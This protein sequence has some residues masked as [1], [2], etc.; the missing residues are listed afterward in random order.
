VAISPERLTGILDVAQGPDYTS[1]LG[2]ALRPEARGGRAFALIRS[3]EVL[4]SALAGLA[5]RGLAIPTMGSSAGQRVAGLLATSSH[6]GDFDLPPPADFV[7]AVH[8]VRADGSSL[9][10]EGARDRAITTAAGAARAAGLD[11]RSVVYDDAL[12]DAARVS[13]GSL[14]VIYALVLEVE[15]M[16]HLRE[17]FARVPWASL[18]EGLRSGQIFVTPPVGTADVVAGEPSTYSYLELLVNPYP[19]DG[20]V[21]AGVVTRFRSRTATAA[22]WQRPEPPMSLADQLRVL[23]T[24]IGRDDDAFADVI[25]QLQAGNRTSSGVYAPAPD[26]C[27]T[28]GDHRVPVQSLEL[29]ISTRGGRHVALLDRLL[30]IFEAGRR[31]GRDF[32]GFWTVRATRMSSAPLAMQARE[33]VDGAGDRIVHVEIAGLQKIDVARPG[34]AN[35]AELEVDNAAFFDAFLDAGRALGARPHWG[36]WTNSRLPHSIFGYERGDAWLDAKRRLAVAGALTAFDNDFSA[37]AG[38]IPLAPGWSVTGAVP[39]SPSRA[40]DDTRLVRSSAPA[41]CV[42]GGVA[43]V[44]AASGDGRLGTSLVGGSWSAAAG[45]GVIAGRVAL[46]ADGAGGML[47]TATLDDGRL[48]FARLRGGAPARLEPLDGGQR[49]T[50]APVPVLDG[51]GTVRVYALERGGALHVRRFLRD[52]DWDGGWS[53]LR[54]SSPV[55]APLPACAALGPTGEIELFAR[56]GGEVLLLRDRAGDLEVAR[57]G[58][59]GAGEAACAATA[60]ATLVA[61]AVSGRVSAMVRRAG[62][63]WFVA[64]TPPLPPVLA[65]TGPAAL[66]VG[67]HIVVG[68]VDTA[69][70][71]VLATRAPDGSWTVRP[72]IE[73]GACGGPAL[74]LLGGSIVLATRLAHDIVQTSA[75]LLGR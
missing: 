68:T 43:A 13:A 6:G 74:A 12:L 58:L 64:E 31:A 16:F 21:E 72:P 50:G 40:P 7:R 54:T 75:I 20:V 46:V 45:D 66:A 53:R 1:P 67:D 56:A 2:Q 14:G 15:P 35:P 62:E 3:G 65:G 36:Q 44:A 51:G 29:A 5:A 27:D 25:D 32:A 60:S 71:V 10:I 24:V 23:T 22:S 63:R 9:W 37:R 30:E 28:G 8:L 4:R 11:E 41:L 26:V 38:L 69:G 17:H 73:A 59:D 39:S 52:G 55:G 57:L 18:R 33:S 48:G 47:A 49:F 34:F 61:A 19:R 70:A 42:S